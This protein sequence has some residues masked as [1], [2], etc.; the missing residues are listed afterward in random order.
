MSNLLF[1]VAAF[2]GLWYVAIAAWVITVRVLE[3]MGLVSDPECH[4]ERCRG[5][6][7]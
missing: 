1:V 2:A 6:R 5:M 7:P 3:P 4:C